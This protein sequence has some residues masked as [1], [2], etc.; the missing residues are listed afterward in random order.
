MQRHRA[1][2]KTLNTW[3]CAY[4]NPK[5]RNSNMESDVYSRRS[6]PVPLPNVYY[7]EDGTDSCTF[8]DVMVPIR[9]VVRRNTLSWSWKYEHYKFTGYASETHEQ[10]SQRP[11]RYT[12]RKCSTPHLSF[13]SL[14]SHLLL[15]LSVSRRVCSVRLA[16]WTASLAVTADTAI[17]N[18]LPIYTWYKW[19]QILLN[20]E[21]SQVDTPHLWYP[22]WPCGSAILRKRGTGNR[23]RS[24]RLPEM[25]HG[26]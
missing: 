25:R 6:Q 7:R 24:C 22:M 20:R 11:F 13:A 14:H 12:R 2:L 15:R 21:R 5:A 19:S 26:N 8:I 1:R 10:I 23:E 9:Y 17:R 18:L 3:G 16:E 4:P